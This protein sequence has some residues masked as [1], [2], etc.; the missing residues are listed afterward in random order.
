MISSTLKST[1]KRMIGK[2]GDSV[3][4]VEVV[5][6]EYDPQVGDTT[7]TVTNYAMKGS[8]SNYGI[9]EMASAAINQGDVAL[10]VSTDLVVNNDWRVEYDGKVWQVIAISPTS[11]QDTVIVRRLQLRC[12]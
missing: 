1:A 12:N 7:D 5:K 10:L 2:Y 11:A 3:V 4:L 8:V 9:E 6:G